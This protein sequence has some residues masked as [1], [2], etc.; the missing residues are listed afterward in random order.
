[1]ISYPTL[2]SLNRFEG[3]KNLAIAIETFAK[4]RRELASEDPHKWALPLRL[5]LGGTSSLSA[6]FIRYLTVVSIV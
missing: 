4:V 6:V 1:M 3:K 5:I 2:L